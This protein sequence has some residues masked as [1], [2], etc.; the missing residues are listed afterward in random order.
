M[1]TW[2]SMRLTRSKEPE[3]D[4]VCTVA[5]RGVL[6]APVAL[7]SGPNSSNDRAALTATLAFA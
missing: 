2:F 7:R 6:F 3:P 5:E 4:D 1:P